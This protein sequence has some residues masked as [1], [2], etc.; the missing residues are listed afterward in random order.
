MN[1]VILGIGAP[2]LTLAIVQLIKWV[3]PEMAGNRWLPLVAVGTGIAL[4]VGYQLSGIS[5]AFA[6]WLETI[7][8]GLLAGL[9]SSGLWDNKRM[10][11]NK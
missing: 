11:E 3:F 8:A 10:A 6:N 9:A 5:P 2:A 7:V 1:F 4:A